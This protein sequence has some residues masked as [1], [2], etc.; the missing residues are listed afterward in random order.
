MKLYTNEGAEGDWESV[1]H[2]R[3][4]TASHSFYHFHYLAN[5]LGDKACLIQPSVE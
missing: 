5:P 2:L 4:P 1:R 3:R